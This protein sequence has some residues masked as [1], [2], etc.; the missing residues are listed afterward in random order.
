M[1]TQYTDVQETRIENEVEGVRETSDESVATRGNVKNTLKDFNEHIEKHYY[2]TSEIDYFFKKIWHFIKRHIF[3]TDYIIDRLGKIRGTHKDNNNYDRIK[4]KPISTESID[5]LTDT[6]NEQFDVFQETYDQKIQET[7]DNLDAHKRDN[8]RHLPVSTASDKGKFLQATG[9]GTYE[10][11]VLEVVRG[12]DSST[13]IT[14]DTRYCTNQS[15]TLPATSVKG[16]MVTVIAT[17]NIYVTFNGSETLYMEANTVQIFWSTGT[18]YVTAHYGAI[19][20]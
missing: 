1:K 19:W 3:H 4:V 2:D 14:Q 11:K 18:K 15:F 20:N 13:P 5:N 8:T 17:G 9:A 10:W 7:N 16:L 6:I 12:A